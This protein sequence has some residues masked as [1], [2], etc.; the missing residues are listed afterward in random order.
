MMRD[1][2]LLRAAIETAGLSARRFAV[3]VLDVD[4]RTV[5]RWIAGDRELQATVRVLCAA[6]VDDPPLAA[7]LAATLSELRSRAA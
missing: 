2:E 3:D 5:R 1:P 4:E 6:I 7:R